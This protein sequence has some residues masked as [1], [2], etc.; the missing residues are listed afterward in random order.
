MGDD[1]DIAQIFDHK[2]LDERPG[3]ARLMGTAL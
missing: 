3:A 2:G 1:G